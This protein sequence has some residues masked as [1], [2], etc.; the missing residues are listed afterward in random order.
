[1]T[2]DEIKA[3]IEIHINELEKDVEPTE[4]QKK[5]MIEALKEAVVII[6]ESNHIPRID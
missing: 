3:L 1:M 4:T 5:R 6:E 2:N